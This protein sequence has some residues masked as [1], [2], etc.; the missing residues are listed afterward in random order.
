MEDNI[1]RVLKYETTTLKEKHGNGRGT[2]M[3]RVSHNL[4]MPPFWE[5]DFCVKYCG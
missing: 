5:V 4:Y 1:V 3:V 2:E